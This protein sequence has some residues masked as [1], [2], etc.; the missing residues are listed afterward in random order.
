VRRSPVSDLLSSAAAAAVLRGFSALLGATIRL[1]AAPG[2]TLA[3]LRRRQDPLI[4][5]FW[6]HELLLASIVLRRELVR[7]GVPIT[8]LVSR[9]RDGEIGARFGRLLGAEVVRGSSSRG[10]GSAL[11]QLIRAA[12]AG[13]WPIV[14]PDGPRGPAR[15]DKPGILVLARLTRIPN[16]PH[17]KDASRA[18]RLGSWDRTI[19][20]RA[21]GAVGVAVGADVLVDPAV[22]PDEPRYTALL[23]TRLDEA[24]AA[25]ARAVDS[26]SS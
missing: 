1:R 22:P 26:G 20:P 3:E 16:V 9:S 13:R 4:L 2:P 5:A 15:A 14:V 18:R 25:A 19:I 7:R 17:G 23:A 11:R 12:K 8:V 10:G 21:F 24:A 6:H